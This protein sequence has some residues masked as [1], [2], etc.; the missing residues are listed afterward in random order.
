[1]LEP[2]PTI[3]ELAALSREF[4]V[5]TDW[6][7]KM[8]P[9]KWRLTDA[10]NRYLGEIMRRNALE[11]LARGDGDWVRPPSSGKPRSH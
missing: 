8:E 1:M 4:A 6:N 9:T 7:K 5:A 2:V 3:G 10:G 11:R